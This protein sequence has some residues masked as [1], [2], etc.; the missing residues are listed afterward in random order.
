[1]F[2]CS[3]APVPFNHTRQLNANRS[4]QQAVWI[5]ASPIE[6]YLVIDTSS[7]MPSTFANGLLRVFLF[8][9]LFFTF[10]QSYSAV[11]GPAGKGVVG[12]WL[13]ALTEI[14]RM[15]GMR[16]GMKWTQRAS[17]RRGGARGGVIPSPGRQP[18]QQAGRQAAGGGEGT[19]HPGKWRLH[20]HRQTPISQLCRGYGGIERRARES[21]STPWH[22]LS[23]KKKQKKKHM[24][25]NYSIA[26]LVFWCDDFRVD[27]VKASVLIRYGFKWLCRD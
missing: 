25:K 5:P 8:L 23:P 14:R 11:P 9:F 1:M 22:D 19:Q 7:K 24:T 21:I 20:G 6:T 2:A 3:C 12:E 18:G 10:T 27:C 4:P 17:L 13:R 26:V 15:L 16:T